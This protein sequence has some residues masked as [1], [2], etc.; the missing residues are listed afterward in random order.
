MKTLKLNIDQLPDFIH[1]SELSRLA[2]VSLPTVDS[3][4]RTGKIS[5]GRKSLSNRYWPKQEVVTALRR[6]GLLIDAE[7]AKTEA[8]RK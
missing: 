1:R 6:I 7:T 4:I 8:K 5:K 2:G 3:W